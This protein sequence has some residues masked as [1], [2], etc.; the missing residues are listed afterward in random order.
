MTSRTKIDV[1]GGT[2]SME[3]GDDVVHVNTFKAMRHPVEEHFILLVDIIDDVVDI[4]DI[5]T[6]LLYDFYDFDL[7]S[8]DCTCDDFDESTVVCS[9]C[10]EISSTIHLIMMRVQVLILLFLFHQPSISLC[11]PQFNHLPLS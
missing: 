1:H 9:I 4:V 2:L 8:L 7:G 6:N 10:A 5:C 3:F 11:L